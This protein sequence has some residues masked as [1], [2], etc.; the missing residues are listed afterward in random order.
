MTRRQLLSRK[1]LAAAALVVFVGAAGAS[2]ALATPG[3]PQGK[4]VAACPTYKLVTPF[5]PWAD[6]GSYYMVP[7]GGFEPPLQ[8]W[9]LSGGASIVTGNES[10]FVNSKKD[11]HALSLP[12]GSSA[13]SPSVCVS[14]YSPDMRVFVRNTGASSTLQVSLNYTDANGN[15]RTASIASL[16]GGSSW[17]LSPYVLFLWQILPVV[18]LDNQTWVSFTFASSGGNWQ[19]DDFYV[20]P[21]KHH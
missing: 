11:S 17:S 7:S 4:Y 13:T 18:G 3:G 1:T 20:D 21:I 15:S 8:A 2:G 16:G 10:Y 19:I 12:A 14:L 6:A 9:S 5:T